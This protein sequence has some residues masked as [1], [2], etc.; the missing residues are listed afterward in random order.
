MKFLKLTCVAFIMTLANI[1]FAQTAAVEIQ[2]E[3]ESVKMETLTVKVKGVGC[4]ND[5]KSIAQNVEK[6]RG[7]SDCEPKS[8]AAISKFKVTYNPAL[9]S[10]EAIHSAIEGTAGCQNPNDRPYSVKL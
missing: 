10:A 6:L 9:V 4:S 7:V 2:Q 1:T 8:K 3:V 5:L